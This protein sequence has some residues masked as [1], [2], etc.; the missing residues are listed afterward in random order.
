[1]QMSGR[2]RMAASGWLQNHYGGA[3]G[4]SGSDKADGKGPALLAHRMYRHRP[5]RCPVGP[6]QTD[7][8]RTPGPAVDKQVCAANRH[9][10]CMYSDKE[11]FMWTHKWV[12]T[13]VYSRSCA[14]ECLGRREGGRRKGERGVK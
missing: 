8:P 12:C 9:G 2:W 7:D 11:P 10:C 14:Y 4:Q 6:G 5:A 3:G 13:C 1:M